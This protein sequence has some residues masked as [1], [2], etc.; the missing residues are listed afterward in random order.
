MQLVD[1]S[2][3]CVALFLGGASYMDLMTKKISNKWIMLWFLVGIF[4]KQ[5]EFLSTFVVVLVVLF[6]FYLFKMFGAGDIKL[7]AIISAYLGIKDAMYIAFVSL[8]F[9]SC[10][11]I[12]YLLKEKILFERLFYFKDFIVRVTVN[13]KIY[14]YYDKN[15]DRKDLVMPMAQWFLI[16][17]L[18]WRMYDL[19]IMI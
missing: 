9:A 2:Q 7:L 16:G 15:V 10:Y 4:I 5:I 8:V 13:K 19:W 1:I 11:S 14:T 12:Y 6:I 18:I 3:I 17:F